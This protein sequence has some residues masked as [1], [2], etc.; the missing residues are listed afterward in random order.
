[1]KRFPLWIL[2]ALLS[3]GIVTVGTG[4]QSGGKIA[5]P[6]S[7]GGPARP[8]PYPAAPFRAPL[9]VA[10][11]NVENLFDTEDDP[12]SDGDDGYAPSRWYRWTEV[13]YRLKL[14]HLAEV[15]VAMKPDILCLVEVENRRVLEDLAQVIAKKEG[16]PKMEIVHSEGG[17]LRGIEVAI[18]SRF[19]P[20]P[21]SCKWKAPF[22]GIRDILSATFVIDNRPLTVMVNHWKS[23]LGRKK[24]SEEM[25]EKCARTL[26]SL[27]EERLDGSASPA[28]LATG[29]F[30]D[31]P[32]S[33]FL[34]RAGA[35]MEPEKGL[36]GG[37]P[38]LVNLNATIPDKKA[39]YSYFYE[40]GGEWSE[41][42]MMLVSAG[43]YT[44]R[45]PWKIRPGS[46]QVF[47]HPLNLTPKGTPLPFRRRWGRGRGDLFITG[48]SDHF[49]IRVELIP[50]D[51]NG[52]GD[53]HPAQPQG[54]VRIVPTR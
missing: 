3:C 29:D 27:V 14:D 47:R 24:E 12:E 42:D 8:V 46:Y 34:A 26:R 54:G 30:N 15:I 52:G 9:V 10:S 44:G 45:S 20:D 19:K 18:L 51:R 17:D 50:S 48:C 28:L 22:P 35:T 36:K 33:T 41:L 6:A 43:L 39:R 1:M 49:P 53:K 31:G 16:R 7:D 11:W 13:R 5:P 32:D 38:L 25:R 23:K 4:C 21:Q 2:L 40:R 37:G